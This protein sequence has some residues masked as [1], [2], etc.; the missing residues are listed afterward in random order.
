MTEYSVLWNTCHES[1]ATAVCQT[2]LRSGIM[3]LKMLHN[4]IQVAPSTLSY[5]GHFVFSDSGGIH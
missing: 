4:S 2:P 5:I 3:K 1:N